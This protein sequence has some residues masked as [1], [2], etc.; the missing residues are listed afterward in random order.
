MGAVEE[1]V[2]TTTLGTFTE[3][4][5]YVPDANAPVSNGHEQA[6][7]DY[8]AFKGTYSN[9]GVGFVSN[10]NTYLEDA[11]T[12]L[13]AMMGVTDFTFDQFMADA[14]ASNQYI[15]ENNSFTFAN[16]SDV[17][18]ANPKTSETMDYM[19]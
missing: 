15:I 3:T 16:T 10:P 14:M 7:M 13:G 9:G 17:L 1:P 19:P 5:E 18:Y 2:V 4:N 11:A 8:T 6:P 12:E